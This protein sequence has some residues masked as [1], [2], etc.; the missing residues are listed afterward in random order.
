MGSFI[1]F[2]CFGPFPRIELL[3]SLALVCAG[4]LVVTLVLSH[5]FF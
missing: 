4:L 2:L 3:S 5:V 1:F